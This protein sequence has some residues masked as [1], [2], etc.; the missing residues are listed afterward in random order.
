MA[1]A[2]AGLMDL[3]SQIRDEA[4]ITSRAGQYASLMSLADDF[5]VALNDLFEGADS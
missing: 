3:V 2:R 1:E 4:N 5:E